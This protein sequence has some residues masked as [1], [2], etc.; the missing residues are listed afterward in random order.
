MISLKT[1]LKQLLENLILI[2][3]TLDTQSMFKMSM[4][5]HTSNKRKIIIL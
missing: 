3:P 4:E 2:N 1:L 5:P